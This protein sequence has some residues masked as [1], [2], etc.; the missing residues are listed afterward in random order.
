MSV[1]TDRC[2]CS[3]VVN[4]LSLKQ[5]KFSWS[6]RDVE[7][8]QT[9]ETVSISFLKYLHYYLH[10]CLFTLFNTQPLKVTMSY[11]LFVL[12]SN[13]FFILMPK[14][15]AL[16]FSISLYYLVFVVIVTEGNDVSQ[17]SGCLSPDRW[18][19]FWRSD[20]T[21]PA[22]TGAWITAKIQQ[23][24]MFY[25][26]LFLD[27]ALKHQSSQVWRSVEGAATQQEKKTSHTQ[28]WRHWSQKSLN[29]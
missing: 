15:G 20:V 27:G 11:K 4:Q 9:L 28:L 26:L 19:S 23:Y 29:H 7:L 25:T 5:R 16:F 18:K 17:S 10:F 21:L 22:L 2:S 3:S 12:L 6:H 14:T 8:I 1:N 13:S 24:K